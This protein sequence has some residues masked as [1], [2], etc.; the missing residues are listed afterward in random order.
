MFF[1][2]I[3][4]LPEA[5]LR[6]NDW[7]LMV[8]ILMSTSKPGSFSKGDIDQYL[9][10]WWRK[11]AITSILNWYRAVIQKPPDISGDLRIK[12]PTLI[13]WGAQDFALS[14]EMA[15]PSLN[16]CDQ[17]KLV[18]FESSSHWVQYDEAEAVNK[19]LLDFFA[20]K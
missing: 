9:H 12:V 5:I 18:Y 8:K 14:R 11:D 19:Y 13:L 16:L 17:G 4:L 2:Q 20:T 15:R 3:P 6:N 7:E 10:A 1:F